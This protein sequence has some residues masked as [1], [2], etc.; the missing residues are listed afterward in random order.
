[1]RKD[2]A[3]LSEIEGVWD[4]KRKGSAEKKKELK[5]EIDEEQA[6]Q[7]A[8]VGDGSRHNDE[9]KELA[10]S[11]EAALGEIES[12]QTA[13]EQAKEGYRAKD[14]QFKKLL[15]ALSADKKKIIDQLQLYKNALASEQDGNADAVHSADADL[16]KLRA[17]YGLSKGAE[18]AGID[19]KIQRT[20]AI[21][22]SMLEPVEKASEVLLAAQEKL[23]EVENAYEFLAQVPSTNDGDDQ[24]AVIRSKFNAKREALGFRLNPSGASWGIK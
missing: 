14:E 10:S 4:E 1:M 12:A 17:K 15:L 22:R 20:V 24:I 2:L 6:R 23:K 21:V 11:K 8:A 3:R 13:L 19:E 18:I 9:K 7:E 5:T 16:S